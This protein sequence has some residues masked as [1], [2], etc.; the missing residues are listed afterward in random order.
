M[1]IFIEGIPKACDMQNCVAMELCFCQGMALEC[2]RIDFLGY[3]DGQAIC[4]K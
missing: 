3:P 2:P 1:K 4:L